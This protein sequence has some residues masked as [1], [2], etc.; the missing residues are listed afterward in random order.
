[1]HESKDVLQETR[2]SATNAVRQMLLFI[3][4][5]LHV[6]RIVPDC[7]HDLG[8]DLRQRDFPRF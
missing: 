3:I 1:M 4:S 8:H 5:R 2:P 7:K 6:Y